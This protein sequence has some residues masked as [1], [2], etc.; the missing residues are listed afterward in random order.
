MNN[1]LRKIV[2]LAMTAW[3]LTL[4]ISC[5]GGGASNGVGGTG[6]TLAKITDLGADGVNDTMTV[7][8]VQYKTDN[9][10]FIRDGIPT[11]QQS[12]YN[13]GEIVTV[14]GVI[15]TNGRSGVASKV[16]FDHTLKGPVTKLAETVS[17]GVFWI[18]VLGQPVTIIDNETI[19]YGFDNLSDLRKSH[20][21]EI[22]GFVNEEQGIVASTIKLISTFTLPDSTIF[23]VEGHISDV[24]LTQQRFLLNNL[25]VDYSNVPLTSYD[26]TGLEDGFFVLVRSSFPL[27]DDD[28]FIATDIFVLGE[29]KLVPNTFHEVQ[30]HITR[31]NSLSDFNLDGNPAV[32]NS[33]TILTNTFT[34]GAGNAPESDFEVNA[35]VVAKGN[36]D[37]NGVLFVDELILI[38]QASKIFV[39]GQVE[40]LDVENETVSVLGITIR[41]ESITFITDEESIQADI[42]N[43]SVGDL[44]SSEA[45]RDIAN[46]SDG[47]YIALAFNK[48][49]FDDQVHIDDTVIDSDE[50]QGVVTLFDHR[51]ETDLETVYMNVLSEVISKQEFFMILAGELSYINLSGVQL[52][53]T[54][55]LA[56]RIQIDVVD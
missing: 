49:E 24:N 31:F 42:N 20:V 48:V 2:T 26:D 38:P 30:V 14:E 52:D 44:I 22:S 15:N 9:A 54:S 32:A 55:I 37:N 19:L 7:K 21:V 35:H 27:T 56:Q 51:I 45:Y 5:G 18:E 43:F 1:G 12:D 46:R 33:Q 53:G 4:L 10:I 25:I 47:S 39:N 23:E 41:I 40:T 34:S 29:G 3:L 28:I 50:Q 17:A 11:T 36:T 16:I 6:I 13:V 8:G